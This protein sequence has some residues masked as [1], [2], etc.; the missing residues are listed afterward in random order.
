MIDWE[1]FINMEK[2]WEDVALRVTKVHGM[3]RWADPIVIKMVIYRVW[4]ISDGGIS[5]GVACKKSS[6]VTKVCILTFCQ[7]LHFKW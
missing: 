7:Q 5:D 4:G 2:K 3:K 1:R 6:S